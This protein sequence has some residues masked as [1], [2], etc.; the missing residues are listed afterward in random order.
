VGS[1]TADKLKE[2][3]E[4]R[5]SLSA[6]LN[7]IERRIP[8]AG[9]GKKIAA[10][11]A[12]SSVA[13]TALAFG[14]RRLRGGRK[15]RKSRMAKRGKGKVA[16]AVVQ[17]AAVTVNVFPKGAAWLAAAGLAGWAGVKVYESITR[18]KKSASPES[19]SFRPAVVTPMPESGR[20]TGN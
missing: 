1:R 14:F 4:V 13:A 19:E 15:A 3:E 11:L 5:G 12:G 6:K 20:Q 2:I 7:E 8:L 9:Y 10:G 17:P 16:D 18:A